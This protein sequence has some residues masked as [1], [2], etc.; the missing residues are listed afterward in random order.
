[1]ETQQEIREILKNALNNLQAARTAFPSVL[2]AKSKPLQPRPQPQAPVSIPARYSAAFAAVEALENFISLQST[3]DAFA[4]AQKLPPA[5]TMQRKRKRSET[6]GNALVHSKKAPFQ[7]QELPTTEAFPPN[8]VTDPSPMDKDS[9]ESYM[10]HVNKQG[11]V[12][13]H[14]WSRS[15]TLQD[16][17]MTD[18]TN[19]IQPTYLRLTIPDLLV[20]YLDI[21]K[22]SDEKGGYQVLLVTVFGAREKKMPHYASDFAVFLKMSQTLTGMLQSHPEADIP[23]MVGLLTSYCD[24][25]NDPCIVCQQCWTVEGDLPPVQRLWIPYSSPSESLDSASGRWVPR[26]HLCAR[27]FA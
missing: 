20:A 7:K 4:A 23:T 18:G 16:N 14:L 8:V 21:E 19:H 5:P 24:L 17:S 10:K 15:R 2:A 22:K 25:Y 11:F 1:M 3:Q 26:H 12:R 13:L 9:L 6:T 27:N